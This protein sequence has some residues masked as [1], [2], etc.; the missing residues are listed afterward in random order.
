MAVVRPGLMG[1]VVAVIV[2]GCAGHTAGR[3]S[4]SSASV[5]GPTTS[6]HL[7]L[8]T[9]PTTEFSRTGLRFDHPRSW[10]EVAF[11]ATRST[12][13]ESIVY[14]SN[15]KLHDPCTRTFSSGGEFITCGAPVSWLPIGG[16]LVSWSNVGF[17][18]SGPEI[19]HPNMT[20][21]GRPALVT[22][23]RHG[24]CDRIGGQE[25]ITADIARPFGNHYE[26]VACLRGPGLQSNEALVRRMLDS[27]FVT[28]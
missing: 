11:T 1:V 8:A 24:D 13:R 23:A 16:V 6:S 5:T 3:R 26:I 12:F 27:T 2:V 25:T 10:L 15:V 19:P 28:G 22:V 21:H 9:E 14:L 17:P 7:N 20:I 4:L 18:H